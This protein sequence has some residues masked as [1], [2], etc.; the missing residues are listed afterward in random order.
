MHHRASLSAMLPV[1]FTAKLADNKTEVHWLAL[2]IVHHRASLSAMLPVTFTAKL[3]D[4]KT[5]FCHSEP[6]GGISEN[7]T[8]DISH[9]FDMTENI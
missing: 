8:R 5:L 1:T 3:A 4:N 9:T 2:P 7:I 6:K